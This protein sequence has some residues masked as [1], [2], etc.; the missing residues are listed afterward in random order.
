MRK[1]TLALVAAMLAMA[2]AP[3]AASAAA[4]ASV[5]PE[6]AVAIATDAYV[7]GYSLVTTDVTR[8]QMSNVAKP[9]ELQA[10]LNQFLNVKRYPPADYRGVSAP[11]ADTLYSIA[12]L[13]LKEPQVFSHPDMGDRF[14]LIP[15][16]RSVDDDLRQSRHPHRRQ[17]GRQLPDHRPGMDRQ[18]T[19]WDD[20]HPRSVAL[21]GDPWPHLCQWHPGR[22]QGHQ[23][24][25]GAVK[26]HP[27]VGLG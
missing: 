18:G 20:A 10:P 2:V 23:R 14:H 4:G 5:T 1:S 26:D 12:W 6:E 19:Q 16:G 13:D 25:A 22:L 21:C 8:I 9:T 7:Y 15:D 27:V 24:V 11:N 17:Q 3:M